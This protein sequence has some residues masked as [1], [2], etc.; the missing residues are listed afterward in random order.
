[1]GDWH[2]THQQQQQQ[3]Q[4]RVERMKKGKGEGGGFLLFCVIGWWTR[5]A[6]QL[7]FIYS[8]FFLSLLL[9]FSFTFRPPPPPLATSV[10]HRHRHPF[11]LIRR[12]TTWLD[13]HM[14]SHSTAA[15]DASA[16]ACVV[17]VVDSIHSSVRFFT[18]VSSQSSFKQGR[19]SARSA[20]SSSLCTHSRNW[21]GL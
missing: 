17:V 1:M 6:A 7:S 19:T 16:D 3:Q 8:P 9:L 2:T 10:Q 18:A 11:G 15:A 12:C 13:S 21:T 14:Q 4:R 5:C 20:A